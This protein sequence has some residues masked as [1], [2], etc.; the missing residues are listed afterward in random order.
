MDNQSI[1]TS[2]SRF[3]NE[4]K[5]KSTRS[6]QFQNLIER[7]KKQWQNIWLI[8]SFIVSQTSDPE[9]K[10]EKNSDSQ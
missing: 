8:K 5:K 2:N 3:L 1:Q 9:Q 7:S 10:P 4:I 6:E